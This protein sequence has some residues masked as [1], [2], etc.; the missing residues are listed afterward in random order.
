MKKNIGNTTGKDSAVL[1]RS[2]ARKLVTMGVAVVMSVLMVCPADVYAGS[3]D[4]PIYIMGVEIGGDY[5]SGNGWSYDEDSRTIILNDF[6][7]E[8]PGVFEVACDEDEDEDEDVEYEYEYDEEDE[9][10]DDEDEEWDDEDEEWDD[11]DEEWDDEDEDQDDEDAEDEDEAPEMV[12][13]VIYSEGNISLELNGNSYIKATSGYAVKCESQKISCGPKGIGK[14]TV[15]NPNGG[16]MTWGFPAPS[17]ETSVEDDRSADETE[18]EEI[19]EAPAIEE[20]RKWEPALDDETSEN[21]DTDDT[22]EAAADGNDTR[23]VAGQSKDT[24]ES[25]TETEEQIEETAE[26]IEE[27]AEPTVSETK[28]PAGDS[29]TVT[30]KTSR[31]RQRRNTGRTAVRKPAGNDSISLSE[32]QTVTPDATDSGS[33]IRIGSTDDEA[34]DTGLEQVPDTAGAEEEDNSRL[35][36]V[37]FITILKVLAVAGAVL[38]VLAKAGIIGG[39]NG[40]TRW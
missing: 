10:W 3:D 34:D 17:D 9:D 40:W 28:E 11:E 4:A 8:G 26:Q 29:V 16:S 22:D 31:G 35:P 19:E 30:E 21:I 27:T 33:D 18:R 20:E 2:I 38:M 13:G 1:V 24:E 6:Y 25:V 36:S 23:S 7:Y 5:T 32:Q 14:L 37:G 12:Y 15:I 39:F